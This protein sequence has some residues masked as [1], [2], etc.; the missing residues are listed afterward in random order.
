MSLYDEMLEAVGDEETAYRAELVAIGRFAKFF[1][2]VVNEEIKAL[3]W[4]NI[5]G[6]VKKDVEI[7]KQNDPEV[8][9]VYEA[10]LCVFRG[11]LE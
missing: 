4:K 3:I 7:I 1:K 2:E 10:C 11:C 6:E 5:P 9:E 8:D